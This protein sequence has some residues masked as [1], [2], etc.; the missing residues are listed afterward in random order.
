[1]SS[2]RE[3]LKLCSLFTAAGTMPLLQK[4]ALANA[5]P[6]APLRIGYLPIT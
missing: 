2:R 6:N 1:M 3:F 4:A 5:D